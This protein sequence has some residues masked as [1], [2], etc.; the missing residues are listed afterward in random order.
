[1][2]TI[3]E[4]LQDFTQS[5][6]PNPYKRNNSYNDDEFIKARREQRIDSRIDDRIDNRID[7][8]INSRSPPSNDNDETFVKGNTPPREKDEE[9]VVRIIL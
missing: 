6:S 8:R 7:D 9:Y 1:M 2:N 5:D 3:E 4:K